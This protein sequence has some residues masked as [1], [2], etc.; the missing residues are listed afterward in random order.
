MVNVFLS[1]LLSRFDIEPVSRRLKASA[2]PRVLMISVRADHGGGPR[3]MELLL[4]GLRGEIDFYI[5]CPN[6]PPYRERFEQLV[7]GN[8]F[9]IPHR[10]FSLLR[11]L[12]LASYV[13]RCEV[14]L[15]H[16]HGKGAGLYGRLVSLLSG[17]PCLH[18]PHGI[19]VAQY[20]ALKRRFY[21]LYENV[22]GRL[23]RHIIYVS[24]EELTAASD[25]GLWPSVP[26]SVIANGVDEISEERVA[27]LRADV[28]RRFE[29]AEDKP[30]VV[31]VS[32]FDF[33]KNMDEAYDVARAL[34][35]MLFLWIGD[36]GGAA[37]LQN[38]AISEKVQNVRF[39]GVLDDPTPVLAAA[40]I[41]FSSSRSE[42]LPL[43]VLEAMAIGLPVV[44]T[45]VTGH[46]EL[47]GKKGG[48]LLYP[49]GE[50]EQAVALLNRLISAPSLRKQLGSRGR[51][52]QRANYS[53][54]R[55]AHAVQ[56]L[57]SG[58]IEDVA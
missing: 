41:Y 5:A 38:R 57:Y 29:I 31:T 44:A 47:V 27:A 52:L 50:S 55:M 4:R 32:R 28:R 22:T 53:A 24:A 30:V 12:Q 17:R 42:G 35:E 26:V 2:I 39:L 34:P 54:R 20:G 43:A 3:H 14:D 37:A 6:E 11:A 9:T 45:N 40:D 58:M 23:A 25:F 19:H 51:D 18:T 49:L 1:F 10:S 15:I 56:R 36:G 8:I 13:K 46:R 48:G 7:H 16:T 21:R 33:A